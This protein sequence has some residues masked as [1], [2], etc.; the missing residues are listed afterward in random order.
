MTTQHK[1]SEVHTVFKLAHW[2]ESAYV[3]HDG[4]KLTR[5]KFDKVYEG[6]IA[7]K[8]TTESLMAY[9]PDGSASFVG[10]ELFEGTIRGRKGTLVIQAAGTSR[11]GIVESRGH[12]V[13]GTGELRD[14]TGTVPYRS[15]QAK[16]Y[17]MVFTLSLP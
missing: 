14:V 3:E 17:P 11:D 7:G 6:E 10:L 5:A 13:A 12:V 2:D 9:A 16:Q 15:G 8:S 1:T 4:V